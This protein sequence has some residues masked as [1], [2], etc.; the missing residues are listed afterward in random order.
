[1]YEVLPETHHDL[2]ALRL[3]GTLD[4]DDYHAFT[5]LIESAIERHGKV[6]LFWEMRDFSGWSPGGAGTDLGFDVRHASDFKRI[7]IVGEKAWHE[8][9]TKLMK[10]FTSAEVKYFEIPEREQALAW[11]AGD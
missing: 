7:A 2:V 1:M 9:M 8:W 4:A 11:V 6:R 5:P 3:S 10:P